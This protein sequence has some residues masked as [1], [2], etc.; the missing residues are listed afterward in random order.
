MLILY[1]MV[2][3][4]QHKKQL[5]IFNQNVFDLCSSFLLIITYAVKLS[6]IRLTGSLGYWLCMLLLNENLF[7]KKTKNQ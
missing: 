6:H 1:G 2:A 7:S 4:K 5:L 3:S